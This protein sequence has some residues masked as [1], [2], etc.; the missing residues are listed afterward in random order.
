M[1]EGSDWTKLSGR[2]TPRIDER[3]ALPQPP[4][5]KPHRVYRVWLPFAG[6]MPARQRDDRA[7]SPRAGPSLPGCRL[8]AFELRIHSGKLVPLC[9]TLSDAF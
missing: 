1:P 4:A 7:G 2:W 6:A 8:A 3:I 5:D 9:L